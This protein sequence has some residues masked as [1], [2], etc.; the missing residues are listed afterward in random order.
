MKEWKKKI[1]KE[2]E[3]RI[4]IGDVRYYQQRISYFVFDGY[5]KESELGTLNIFQKLFNE[6]KNEEKLRKYTASVFIFVKVNIVF[7][8]VKY[9]CVYVH[10]M[11]ISRQNSN[12]KL[13]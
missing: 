3:C 4:E 2:N 11:K 8:A 10:F 7:P 1:K 13:K 12:K 9:V 6:K 5:L